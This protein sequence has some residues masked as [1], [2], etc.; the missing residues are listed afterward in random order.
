MNLKKKVLFGMNIVDEDVCRIRDYL[1][2]RIRA[3]E[4]T[5]VVTINPEIFYYALK[6]KWYYDLIKKADLILPD[7]IGILISSAILGQK[8]KNRS[9]GIDL[10]MSFLESGEKVS[11]FLLGTKNEILEDAVKVIKDKYPSVNLVGY[12]HGFFKESDEDKVLDKIGDLKPD[13]LL[14]GMGFPRQE[15]LA[16]KATLN[17]YATIAIGVGGAIDVISGRKKRAPAIFRNL[18]L[19]WLWR[20]ILEPKRI[21]RLFVIPKFVLFSIYSRFCKNQEGRL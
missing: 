4:K 5:F 14:I 15:K 20:V 2:E 11:V 16:Y 10:I 9:T 18:G 21:R 13:L 17:G 12:H 6:N 19:E 8:I 1:L 7:G 3:R